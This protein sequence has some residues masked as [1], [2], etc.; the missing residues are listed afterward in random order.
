MADESDTEDGSNVVELKPP[1]RTRRRPSTIDLLPK[2]IRDALNDAIADGR[3]SVDALW[4]LVKE[5][6]GEVSRSAVGR[7]KV[8]EE[9]ALANMLEAQRM[10]AAMMRESSKD[11]NGGVSKLLNTL[12][13]SAA[14]RRLMSMTPAQVEKLDPKDLNFLANMAKSTA[15]SDKI[16]AE[17]EAMIRDRAIKQ[18][19]AQQAAA[20]NKAEKKGDLDKE[21]AQKARRILGF[22]E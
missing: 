19:R 9:R 20:L 18:E 14:Y 22:A 10:A 3:M 1:R 2:D 16:L 6:G 8:Q 4:G 17:R 5:R 13:Q 15:Q 21:A 7:H 12:V 11:P